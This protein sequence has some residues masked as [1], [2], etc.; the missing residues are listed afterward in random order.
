[1]PG[2]SYA[3]LRISVSPAT[4]APSGANPNASGGGGDSGASPEK[5]SGGKPP[6]TPKPPATEPK[7]K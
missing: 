6:S 1:V 3:T 7:A 5:K 2:V 4:G